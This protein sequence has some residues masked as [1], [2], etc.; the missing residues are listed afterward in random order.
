MT[1]S[2]NLKELQIYYHYAVKCMTML[3]LRSIAFASAVYIDTLLGCL[4]PG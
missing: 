2:V 4:S 1:R 3:D